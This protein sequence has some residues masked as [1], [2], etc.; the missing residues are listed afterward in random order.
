MSEFA[1]EGTV[2]SASRRARVISSIIVKEW[3][4]LSRDARLKGLFALVVL[5]MLGA[6]AF[7]ATHRQH[8]DRE[9]AAA[10]Q[11]DRALWTSQGAKD[12]HAA[13]H[14]GQYAFKPESPLALADPGVDAYVGAAVW[15]EAHKQ[16][17]PRFRAAR[18]AGSTARLGG[19]S[20]A[21]VLRTIMPLV[22]ILICF[23]GFSGERERGTL[24]QLASLGIAPGDLL[25]GKALAAISVLMALL[26]PA[27]FVTAG[28]AALLSDP[29][30][31]STADQ[32]ARVG[33]LATGYGAYLLG[34]VFLALAVSALAPSSRAALLALL[35]FWIVNCF[36]APRVMTEA[37]S[38]LSPLPTALEFRQRID[39]DKA[40]TFGHDE[41]HPAFLAF[42]DDVL[43]RNGVSRIEGLPV[44]FRGLALRKDDENGYVIFDRH[45]ASL[46]AAF[47]V[48]DK[49]RSAIGFVFP[50]LALEPWST[51]FAGTDTWHQYNFATAAE[52]HRHEIQTMVSDDLIRNGRYGDPSY[53]A[54]PELWARIGSFD[55]R[56]PG[57]GFAVA[58]VAIDFLWLAL[59]LGW[60]WAFAL[61]AARRL[62]PI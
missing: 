13:A 43:K 7:G 39:A 3:R 55:Y 27:L 47:D 41:K 61:F 33:A 18:D 37:A 29:D 44:N 21:F 56:A 54:G 34:V 30:H 15:L 48:Q 58:H 20:L 22:V 31:F 12:P 1:I 6:L 10:A 14:F 46:Q 42:R 36:L 9:R 51:S 5:L 35:A 59:W 52:A 60:T 57:V 40:R 19:L 4:E 62:R 24:R 45:F 8:L 16:N 25:V 38:A 26:L 2:V 28:C 50:A 53:A 49:M 32:L 17:E 23:S 11:A